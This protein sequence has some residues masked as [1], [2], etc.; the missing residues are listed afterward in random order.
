MAWNA[1][2]T[3]RGSSSTRRQVRQ[4]I[5]PVPLQQCGEGE[6]GPLTPP[7][8]P[9]QEFAVGQ[10]ARGALPKSVRIWRMQRGTVARVDRHPESVS[11]LPLSLVLSQ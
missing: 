4:T 6:L 9:A 2:S 7:R 1:S 10:A 5:P 11:G 8:E 3:S